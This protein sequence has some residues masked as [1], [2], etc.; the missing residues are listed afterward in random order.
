[1]VPGNAVY[2][3][4]QQRAVSIGNQDLKAETAKV[5]TTGVVFEPPQVK[6]LAFTADLSWSRLDQ[7]YSGFIARPG[8]ATAAKPAAVYELK[9]GK[10][11]LIQFEFDPKTGRYTIDKIL[12]DGYL[13]VGK[14]QLRFHREN[15]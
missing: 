13:R 8:I 12:D 14:S 4:R 3:T 1:M 9:D 6:G 5:I 11:S 2:N 15:G 10:P 7:K